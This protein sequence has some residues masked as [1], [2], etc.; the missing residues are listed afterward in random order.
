MIKHVLYYSQ[1]K[2]TRSR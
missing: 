1:E 2:G